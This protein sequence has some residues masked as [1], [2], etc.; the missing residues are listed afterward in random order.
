[1]TNKN[2]QC[3]MDFS[4]L[5]I[6]YYL[7]IRHQD[8]WRVFKIYKRSQPECARPRAQQMPSAKSAWNYGKLVVGGHGCGRGRPHSAF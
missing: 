8:L 4:G 6:W 7:G 2:P 3:A 5:V 1:M